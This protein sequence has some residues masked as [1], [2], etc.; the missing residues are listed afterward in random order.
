[1]FAC[2][3]VKPRGWQG[4]GSLFPCLEEWKKMIINCDRKLIIDIM[5]VQSILGETIGKVFTCLKNK[6]IA[7]YIYICGFDRKDK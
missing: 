5:C 4:V 2:T 3:K 1:M 7:G 6:Q